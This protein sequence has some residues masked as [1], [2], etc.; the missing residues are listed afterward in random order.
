[1]PTPHETPTPTG[2]TPHQVPDRQP[3]SQVLPPQQTPTPHETPTPTGQTPHQVPDRQP[4][5]QVLPPQQTPTPHE[6]P[7]PTGQ[8]PHQVPDRQPPSERGHVTTPGVLPQPNG[9]RTPG[10][11]TNQVPPVASASTHSSQTPGQVS[12]GTPI[13]PAATADAGPLSRHATA[14][15]TSGLGAPP[16]GELAHTGADGVGLLAGIAASLVAAGSGLV[17][18]GRR[19]EKDEED[20]SDAV[21]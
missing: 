21:E 16:E 11:V 17:L 9:A 7:T 6:T 3:P 10:Q 12:D 20:S 1:T 2:Q 5:S 19:R 18:A 14:A 8:T 4:P 15:P 13:H